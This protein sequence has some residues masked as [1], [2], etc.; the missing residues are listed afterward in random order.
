VVVIMPFGG[1]ATY[2]RSPK[3][4]ILGSGLTGLAISRALSKAGIQ[5]VL[6]G[7][8]PSKTPRLGESLNAEGSLEI[9]RQF[10][11][12]LRFFTPKRRQVLF[13]G[14]HGLA[15]DFLHL[16][17]YQSLN[18]LLGYPRT[19]DF[20]HVD[21]I[22]FDA[23][24]FEAAVADSH[25]THIESQAASLN[26]QNSMDRIEAVVLENGRSL[27]SSYVF[28][29][30]NQIRFVALK[31]G[32]PRTRIGSG[33]RVVFA[34]YRRAG[35]E[36]D[37]KAATGMALLDEP[38]GPLPL[39]TEESGGILWSGGQAAFAAAATE[40]SGRLVSRPWLQATSLLRLEARR[41]GVEGLAWCIPLRGYV[42]VGISVDPRTVATSP[43][44]LLDAVERAY[45]L[46]GID[47]RGAFPERSAPLD[48][49]YE[50]Y[51]H[52]R[53]AGRNWLLTGPTCCQF[54]FPS[55]AG[56]ATGLIAARLAPDLLRTPRETAALYQD[57]IDRLAA[58]HTGLDWLVADDPALMTRETLER[59]AEA[60]VG[61]NIQRLGRYL[62]LQPPPPE[63]AFGKALGSWY[64]ADRKLANPS[65][66]Q[67]APLEALGTRTFSGSYAF[68]SP[69]DGGRL[70]RADHP[71]APPAILDLVETLSGRLASENGRL[72]VMP[73]I[74]I[75]IGDFT[76]RGLEG[77]N[78]WVDL[79]RGSRRVANLE[80]VP[81]PLAADNDG[82][83]L[84]CQWQGRKGGVAA[85]S[86]PFWMG[87]ILNDER[88][89]DLQTRRAD[90]GF[91]LG[92]AAMSRV[93]WVVMLK[94]LSDREAA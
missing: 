82:W 23:A 67:A 20:L 70:T 14:E 64:Q 94:Q 36:L 39:P 80:L 37:T 34:H 26:Y 12:F 59:R 85:Y 87:F 90:Y 74:R 1:H 10:P 15:I 71:N 89:A 57:Y 28:D 91:V 62:G 35:S 46:H 68:T 29:A 66:V 27:A 79:I 16:V 73:D 19:V 47:V 56:V 78:A 88:V 25:C 84:T 33:R 18:G 55:A 72:L 81:G 53:C 77:W 43:A 44:L 7:D 22:G 5:H 3:P 45:A 42:S 75:Y 17:S 60:M 49:P 32:V 92:D 4:V 54:W 58:A 31:L 86:P 63:L 83:V 40:A 24:L 13:F 21:R 93:G 52:E 69:T 2:R 50:H 41:Y 11:D 48:F 65:T 51:N 76:L 8:K 38:S 61:G 30:T 9:A 6:V